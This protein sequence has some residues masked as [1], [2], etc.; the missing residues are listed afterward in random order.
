MYLLC[1]CCCVCDMYKLY[2][3]PARHN[4]RCAPLSAHNWGPEQ[5]PFMLPCGALIFLRLGLE[6][7]RVATHFGTQGPL[8]Q[9]FV[10]IY[11]RP[12]VASYSNPKVS[13]SSSPAFL[14]CIMCTCICFMLFRS[15]CSC[16]FSVENPLR[17]ATEALNIHLVSC[18]LYLVSC[19]LYLV[20]VKKD[21][22][23][24]G[25]LIP[26]PTLKTKQRPPYI[27]KKA[28]RSTKL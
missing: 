24:V 10:N 19:I 14:Y 13:I 26:K 7:E 11:P 4:C 25:L 6:Q 12:P 18:I 21:P 20:N 27:K 23:K 9:T 2:I 3:V 5:S 22:P 1:C 15:T 17:V 28:K 16:P 8:C